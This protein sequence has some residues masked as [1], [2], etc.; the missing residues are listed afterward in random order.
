MSRDLDSCRVRGF[1]GDSRASAVIDTPLQF[2]KY[3]CATPEL[4]RHFRELDLLAPV[5]L[6]RSNTE[7]LERCPPP[8]L[9]ARLSRFTGR[10]DPGD[11]GFLLL[12]HPTL[13]SRP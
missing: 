13:E 11:G 12:I 4:D 8:F 1:I 10:K 6:L 2:Y 9:E 5:A 7:F 3:S